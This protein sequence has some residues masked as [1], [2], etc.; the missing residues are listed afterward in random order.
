MNTKL[1]QIFN[2]GKMFGKKDS[3]LGWL[4]FTAI[5]LLFMMLGAREI[6]THEWRWAEV[7]RE[8]LIRHDYLHPYFENKPYYDKPLLSYWLMLISSTLW[9]SL[10]EWSLRLPSALAGLLTIFCSYLTGSKLLNKRIGLVTGWLLVTNYFFIFWARTASA[11][12]LNVCGIMLAFVWYIFHRDKASFFSYCVFFIILAL[13]SLIKGL[14]GA[15]IPLLLIL[16]DLMVNYRWRR[17]L[18]AKC[19]LAIVPAVLVYLVPFYLSMHFGETSYHENGLSKV[20]H[21]NFVRYFHPFDHDDPFYTYLIY[22]PL[23]LLPWSPFFILAVFTLKKQWRM[24]SESQKWLW[25][26]S[27]FVFL[28]LSLSGSRRS[29]YVLPLVP[30]ATI[31]TADWLVSWIKSRPSA[32]RYINYGISFFVL[33][34]FCYFCVMQPI[35]YLRGGVKD[36]AQQLEEIAQNIQPWHE[37]HVFLFSA[38]DKVHFY[39]DSSAVVK[40]FEYLPKR[41]KNNLINYPLLRDRPLLFLQ[42]NSIIVTKECYR[43][44]VAKNLGGY[45]QVVTMRSHFLAKKRDPEDPVA[46][47]IYEQKKISG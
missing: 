17:H 25:W 21:E 31:L 30:I 45:Y 14:I 9:G 34:M 20:F 40:H 22:L 47:L 41:K 12:I 6:W 27:L 26:A 18:R 3:R 39:L 44:L 16:P 46:F 5:I 10:S 36:F 37:W 32:S 2:T 42:N 23:Y 19:F 33:L 28:F 13:T 24:L 35:Y 1:Y 7:L 15:I 4:F 11:D 29:Y 38:K 8:M 43:D